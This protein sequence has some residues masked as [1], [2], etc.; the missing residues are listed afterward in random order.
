[1]PDINLFSDLR[2]GSGKNTQGRV[3]SCTNGVKSL[4]NFK[5]WRNKCQSACMI[6]VAARHLNV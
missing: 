2:C 6:Y 3:T 5:T 4:I 1:M